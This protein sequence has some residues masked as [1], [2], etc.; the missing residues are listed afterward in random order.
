MKNTLKKFIN[1]NFINACNY[2]DASDLLPISDILITDY[3]SLFYQYA[4][5]NRLIVFY[6]Y[7]YEEYIKLRGGFY[8]DYEKELPG[9]ICKTEDEL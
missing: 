6:P 2:P 5:L 8:L 7:D 1:S 9:P 4:P 3:S